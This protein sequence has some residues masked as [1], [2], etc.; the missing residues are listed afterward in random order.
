MQPGMPCPPVPSLPARTG[1]GGSLSGLLQAQGRSQGAGGAELQEECTQAGHGCHTVLAI[2]ARVRAAA[3]PARLQ[4]TAADS[5]EA[6]S[7]HPVPL[8]SATYRISAA[9]QELT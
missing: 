2:Q 1:P 6:L 4:P 7:A 5:Q 3:Q 9:R 8:P